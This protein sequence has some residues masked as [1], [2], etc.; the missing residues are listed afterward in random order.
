MQ[1]EQKSTKYHI[2]NVLV[3]ENLDPIQELADPASYI[4]LYRMDGK[5]FVNTF[6][7]PD[8]FK[9]FNE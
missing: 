3:T 6:V 5:K 8:L 9:I 4:P 7:H 2:L 1:R